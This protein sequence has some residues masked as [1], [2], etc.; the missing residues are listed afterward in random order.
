VH[1][2]QP[3]KVK[4]MPNGDSRARAAVGHGSK[5]ALDELNRRERPKPKPAQVRV[6]HKRNGGSAG[7]E[8]RDDESG[9]AQPR[10]GRG[11]R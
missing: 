3:M 8:Q 7:P 9:Q 1:D 10:P 2:G 5:S 11:I 4:A 6:V